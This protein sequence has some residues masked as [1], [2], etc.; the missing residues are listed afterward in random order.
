MM[1]LNSLDKYLQLNERHSKRKD[2]KR[3]K[4]KGKKGAPTTD[5][6]DELPTLHKVSTAFDVPEV[7]W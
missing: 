1:G 7:S 4:R 5:S 6:E 3:K 2:K